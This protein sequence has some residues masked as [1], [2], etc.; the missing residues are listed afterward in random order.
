MTQ[1]RRRPLQRAKG[2]ECVL[3]SAQ[4]FVHM[5]M[6]IVLQ[7][8]AASGGMFGNLTQQKRGSEDYA[9][10]RA[11]HSDQL[12]SGGAVSGKRQSQRLIPISDPVTDF[13]L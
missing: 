8:S 9:I 7:S 6:L 10:R 13:P 3:Q 1:R 4:R 5:L 12:I 11:S 2:E